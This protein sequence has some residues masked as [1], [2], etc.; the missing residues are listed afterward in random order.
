REDAQRAIAQH[1][2]YGARWPGID[3]PVLATVTALRDDDPTNLQPGLKL[4]E[5]GDLAG[6]IAAHEAALARDP[7]IAQAHGNLISLYG[8]TR[9]WAKAEEHYRAVVAL[10][11][12]LGDAHYDYGVLLGLQ[13]QWDLAADAYRRAIA[14]NPQHAG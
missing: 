3:D 4:A 13:E 6:A 10:G 9:N 11:V 5:A 7:S 12:N 14:V 2:R 8:N 1:T